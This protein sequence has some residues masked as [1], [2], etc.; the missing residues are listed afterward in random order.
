MMLH[1][2]SYLLLSHGT[3]PSKPDSQ[4][5]TDAILGVRRVE[6]YSGRVICRR[7]CGIMG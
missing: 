2:S 3:L 4:S 7:V 1:P 5:G 6:R